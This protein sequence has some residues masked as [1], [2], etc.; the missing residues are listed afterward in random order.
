[1]SKIDSLLSRLIV[2]SKGVSTAERQAEARVKTNEYFDFDRKEMRD[3][4]LLGIVKEAEAQIIALRAATS[5]AALIEVYDA[6]LSV[7]TKWTDAKAA[8]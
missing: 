5:D 4:G 8:A 1:M 6:S 3:S 7:F 2:A